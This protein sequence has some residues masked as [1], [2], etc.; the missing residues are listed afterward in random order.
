[1]FRMVTEF[2]GDGV[3]MCASEYP[4]SECQFSNSVDNIL[5]WT[6]LTREKLLSSNGH[7]LLPEQLSAAPGMAGRRAAPYTE[8]S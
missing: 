1:M 6:S 8:F 2:L 7:A 5:A 4:D 3:L